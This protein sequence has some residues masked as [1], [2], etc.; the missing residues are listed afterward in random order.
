MAQFFKKI[1][2]CHI[3][4]NKGWVH[5]GGGEYCVRLI[6]KKLREFYPVE[7]GDSVD[8]MRLLS[9]DDAML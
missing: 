7:V 4:L 9:A 1:I 8:K 6:G 5:P 2:C 3:G